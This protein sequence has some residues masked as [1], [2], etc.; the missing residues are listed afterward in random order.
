MVKSLEKAVV[1]IEDSVSHD[2]IE[3]ERCRCFKS[4]CVPS[5]SPLVKDVIPTH[6]SLAYTMGLSMTQEL[7]FPALPYFLRDIWIIIE[8]MVTVIQVILAIINIQSSNRFAVDVVYICLAMLN[9]LLA[10]LDG[11]LYYYELGS[12][13]QFLKMCFKKEKVKEDNA[14]SVQSKRWCKY[15]HLSEKKRAKLNQWFEV[16]RTVLSEL[17][18]YPLIIFDL[19]DISQSSFISQS[20]NFS[21]FLISSLFMV[22]SVYL[23]RT[24]I[25]IFTLRTLLKLLVKTSTGPSN[26]RFMIRFFVHILTQIVVHLSCIIAVGIKIHLENSQSPSLSVSPFLWVAM[27]AGW[28][29][30]FVGVVMFGVANYFWVQQYSIGLCVEVMSLVQV[31][32]IAQSLFK[33]AADIESD[34]AAKSKEIL[35]KMKLKTVKEDYCKKVENCKNLTKFVYP[36]RILTFVLLALLYNGLLFIFFVCLVLTVVNGQVCF[37]DFEEP[38]SVLMIGCMFVIALGNLHIMLLSPLLPVANLFSVCQRALK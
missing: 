20:L 11:F 24:L 17:L 4:C 35:E 7:L 23:A 6:L 25:T 34:M 37:I 8:L 22:L 13:K 26:I 30:P 32:N 1:T 27:V 31:P 10:L 12:Y 21:I 14:E 28:V 2:D 19:F 29:V 16:I 33:S 36:S 38:A 9:A 5:E 18:L 3:H 15:I